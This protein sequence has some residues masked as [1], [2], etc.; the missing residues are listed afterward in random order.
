MD[1]HPVLRKCPYQFQ[2]AQD[3]AVLQDLD[4]DPAVQRGGLNQVRAA[5]NPANRPKAN[6]IPGRL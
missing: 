2:V 1:H 3:P 5:Q 4:Q 6:A